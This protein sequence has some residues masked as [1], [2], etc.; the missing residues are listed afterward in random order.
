MGLFDAPTEC[1]THR[2]KPWLGRV[3]IPPVKESDE[4]G[5]NSALGIDVIARVVTFIS[6]TNSPGLAQ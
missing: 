6:A 2:T 1:R 4:V 3:R 5:Q